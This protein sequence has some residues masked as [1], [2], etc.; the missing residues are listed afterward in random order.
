MT[1]C[2][3]QVDRRRSRGP[4]IWITACVLPLLVWTLLPEN[5]RVA[6]LCHDDGIYTVLA[7]S[8]VDRGVYR[9]G[10]HPEPIETAKYPPAVPLIVA[11]C[12]TVT[13]NLD[14]A[15]TAVRIVNALFLALALASFWGILAQEG[16][17]RAAPAL[18]FAIGWSTS[19]ADFVR[20]CMSEVPYLGVSLFT[21]YQ[22]LRFEAADEKP[23]RHGAI[24]A[25]LCFAAFATRSFGVVLLLT[26]GLHLV[27]AK[28]IPTAIRFGAVLLPMVIALQLFMSHVATPAKGYED[29]TVYG[30]PYSRIFLNSLDWIGAT[31]WTNTLHA[32]L[33]GMQQIWPA[34]TWI[35][36]TG[37]IGLIALW[38]LV[39][40]TIVL[41]CF[42]ARH[43]SRLAT[44]T[45]S[46]RP[47][48]VL[49]L[50][51]IAVMLPWPASVGRF[52]IPLVPFFLL[53]IVRGVERVVG[54]RSVPMTAIV[55][56]LA[57]ISHSIGTRVVHKEN[58]VAFA[59]R[60]YDLVGL[61]DFSKR[62]GSH[63]AGQDVIVACTAESLLASHDGIRGVWGWTIT[64]DEHIYRN[65]ESALEFHLGLSKWEWVRRELFAARVLYLEQTN[66]KDLP[67]A[68][69]MMQEMYGVPNPHRRNDDR[70][71]LLR[72][73]ERDTPKVRDQY[74]RLGVTHAVLLLDQGNPLY[75]VLLAR[76]VR[77]LLDEGRA[78]LVP[79]VSSESIQVFRIRP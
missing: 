6:G 17:G 50:G 71:D 66:S 8:I 1:M 22:L 26:V 67:M 32:A 10:H 78:T 12:L 13:P 21:I 63:T 40:L 77:R 16:L 38:A 47:W 19:S 20:V 69:S 48:H 23:W 28:R 7:Q 45:L 30:L 58:A 79:E 41:L 4:A 68:H 36:P 5:P 70:E 46:I 39:L 35:P 52:L 59:G 43:E 33:S 72:D 3:D 44:D 65:P 55:L 64:A 9:A 73:L 75:E 34:A 14:T 29:V 57:S 49:I 18:V 61:L 27:L 56:C 15:I 74:R 60:D 2:G 76:L 54:A 51:S 24:L 53:M 11:A 42:G 31:T 62:L 37:T 25:G